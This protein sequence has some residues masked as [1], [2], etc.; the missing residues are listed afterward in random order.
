MTVMIAYPHANTVGHNFHHSLTLTLLAYRDLIADI[1]GLRCNPGDGLIQGRNRL[2]NN[3]LE[4]DADHLWMLDTD[5][6]FT[7]DTLSRMLAHDKPVVS[8]LYYSPY[9]MEHDG[10]GGFYTRTL[11][12]A[13]DKQGRQ[14]EEGKGVFEVGYVGAGCMLVSRD[15]ARRVDIKSNGKFFD[16]M[17]DKTGGN[18]GEDYSF[19]RRLRSAGVPITVDADLNISHYKGVWV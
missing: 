18:Y 15:A 16:I 5:I 6:G 2:M 13:A 11:P 12:V 17:K 4:S 1:S 3:F 8:A 19:C 10:R 14:I 9:E 7:P